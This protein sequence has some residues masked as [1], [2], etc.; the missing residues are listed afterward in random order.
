MSMSSAYAMG[1]ELSPISLSVSKPHPQ[2]QSIS[3]VTLNSEA[4]IVSSPSKNSGRAVMPS[5]AGVLRKKRRHIAI[6]TGSQSPRV[7]F[8]EDKDAGEI[9]RRSALLLRMERASS[10]SPSRHLPYGASIER[11]SKHIEPCCIP[12]P[13]DLSSGSSPYM[14]QQALERLQCRMSCSPTRIS[15]TQASSGSMD[16]LDSQWSLSTSSSEEAERT[17]SDSFYDYW[18]STRLG[19]PLRAGWCPGTPTLLSLQATS[20][21]EI[22]LPISTEILS[23]VESLDGSFSVT[24][25]CLRM[26]DKLTDYTPPSPP[27]SLDPFPWY[28]RSSRDK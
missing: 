6:R 1:R 9:S 7:L 25:G 16:T 15:P 14:D 23:P 20:L 5:N 8:Q 18:I 4:I 10:K 2:G 11:P 17:D 21:K 13:T 27:P 12:L 19:S 3:N 26:W 22:G 24:S 28:R